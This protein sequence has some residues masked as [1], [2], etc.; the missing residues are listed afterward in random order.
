MELGELV[1]L[2]K[3]LE[4]GELVEL[5]EV[6]ELVESLWSLGHETSSGA[7]A[8]KVSVLFLVSFSSF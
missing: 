2:A 3:V 5:A 8:L 6:G 7:L 4:I 1:E